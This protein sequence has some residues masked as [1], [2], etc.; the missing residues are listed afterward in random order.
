MPVE[1]IESYRDWT[2]PVEVRRIVVG[3]LRSVSE[4]HL[5]GLGS[6][7]LTSSKESN[8]SFRRKKVKHR[9]RKRNSVNATGSYQ[10]AWPGNAAFVR[11]YVDNILAQYPPWAWRISFIPEL[12]FADTLFHEIGHH[13]H[14]T[15]V[16][17]FRQREGVADDWSHHLTRQYFGKRYWF[18]VRLSNW[19]ARVG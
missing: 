12:L 14:L 7:I 6:I 11:L 5:A 18:V 9:G 1:I 15:K 19:I 3:L 10:P 17:E 16:R 8:R 4:K 2:P 13:V